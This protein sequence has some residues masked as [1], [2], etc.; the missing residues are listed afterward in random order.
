MKVPGLRSFENYRNKE[1]LLRK[2]EEIVLKIED[3]AYGGLGVAR[4]DGV[5]VFVEKGLPGQTVRAR[6]MKKK[7]D[8]LT[9]RVLDVLKPADYEVPPKCAHFGVCGGCKWQNVDY[10]QQLQFKQKIVRDSLQ[11]IGG[12]YAVSVQPTLSSPDVFFYRNKM[13]FSFSDKRWLLSNQEQDEKPKDFA[14]GLHVP[15]RY[16]KIVDIDTCYLQSPESNRL[17]NLVKKFTR[18]SGEK[19]WSTASHTG[20]WRHLVIR[21]GKHTGQRMVNVVTSEKN[22]ALMNRLKEKILESGIPVSSFVNNINRSKGSTAFGEEEWTVWGDRIIEEKLGSYRFKISANSFF[23]T[24]TKQ[25]ERL[26]DTVI[27]LSGFTGN[28]IVYD[29]YSGTGTISIYISKRVQRVLGVEAMEAAIQD[30]RRN[31]ALNQ[32]ENVEFVLGDVKDEM[33]RIE[34]LMNVVGHP[35]V[36]IIDPPRAGLHPKSLQSILKLAPEKIVYVSC[37]PTT[38]ARDL[39]EW[40]DRYI[41]R[42]VQPVDMFPHTYHIE[43]VALLER[44]S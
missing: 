23:Q 20:F 5:V 21:E 25:A 37:N 11:R 17:L 31:K 2:G 29:L 42:Y 19:P 4:I 13:E 44:K 34:E 33:K 10:S 40:K 15:R 36:F 7:S 12:F 24:N 27:D 9:A 16:D 35:D 32:T 30:A 3:V 14:L 6:V 1:K 43:T 39:S 26:Y 22:E 8:Y 41:L 28:E 18:E 38:L